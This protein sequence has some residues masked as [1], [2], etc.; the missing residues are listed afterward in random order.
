MTSKYRNGGKKINNF[1]CDNFNNFLPVSNN[2]RFSNFRDRGRGFGG[3]RRGR[4]FTI[5]GRD[6]FNNHVGCYSNY[7]HYENQPL[8]LVNLNFWQISNLPVFSNS[9]TS[10]S[11]AA[12]AAI[13]TAATSLSR[14]LP[15]LYFYVPSLLPSSSST[16]RPIVTT[17]NMDYN[18]RYVN[19]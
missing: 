18:T 15:F 7:N 1:N 13:A 16:S 10:S 12:A 17:S 19:L 11:S 14:Y 6:I 3:G 2:L 5:S 4:N 8:F 9:R